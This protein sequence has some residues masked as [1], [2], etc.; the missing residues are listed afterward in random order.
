MDGIEQQVRAIENKVED[1]TGNI[2]EI[3]RIHNVTHEKQHEIY[4]EAWGERMN[5]LIQ[6]VQQI[7]NKLDKLATTEDVEQL[8]LRVRKLELELHSLQVDK[9]ADD[10]HKAMW[11]LV[12]ITLLSAL[13]GLLSNVL[14]YVIS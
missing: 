5:S 1:F 4:Q 2:K 7:Q 8:E 3:M 11:F 9:K 12:G 6:S 14:G 10:D 13:F